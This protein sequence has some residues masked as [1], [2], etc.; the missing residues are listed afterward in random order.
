MSGPAPA[1]AG[2]A[3]ALAALVL[4]ARYPPLL[5]LG[6]AGPDLLLALLVLASAQPRARLGAAVLLGALRDATG[7]G[8]AGL[9]AAG[10]LLAGTLVRRL[11]GRRR[12]VALAPVL[13]LL[14]PACALAYAP[15][16]LHAVLACGMP[17]G[18]AAELVFCT[19]VLSAAFAPVPVLLLAAVATFARNRE[20]C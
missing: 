1:L 9:F 4:E 2:A 6:G 12:L 14:P 11:V 5:R 7:G 19:A 3:L 16:A 15:A 13:A 18:R 10:F 20:A 17:P 8:P